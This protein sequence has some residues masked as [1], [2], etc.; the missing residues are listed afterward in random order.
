M[1]EQGTILET[2]MH[3]QCLS[4][5][6]YKFV[7]LKL[8]EFTGALEEVGLFFCV[9]S[10]KKQEGYTRLFQLLEDHFQCGFILFTKPLKP[11]RWEGAL[12][13]M[14]DAL[15]LEKR[16]EMVLRIV[17]FQASDYEQSDLCDFFKT[18]F[19]EGE[20][21]VLEEMQAHLGTVLSLEAQQEQSQ[22]LQFSLQPKD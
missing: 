18:H 22:H 1:A 14:E 5:E 11:L 15:D 16:L 12:K 10:E 7:G 13:A 4:I 17:Y 8:L 19:L 2:V 20:Q 9:L 3:L 21:K 6:T